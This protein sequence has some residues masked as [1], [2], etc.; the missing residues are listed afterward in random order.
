MSALEG[1]IKNSVISTGGFDHA[2][3]LLVASLQQSSST[4][5]GSADLVF[6]KVSYLLETIQKPAWSLRPRIYL[7]LH[8][9]GHVDLMDN[10]VDEGILDIH[11][12]FTEERLPAALDDSTSR[13]KFIETQSVVLTMATNDLASLEGGRHRNFGIIDII[14]LGVT[15]IMKQQQIRFTVSFT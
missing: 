10:F 15:L 14:F 4:L 8:I 3:G 6:D 2:M 12:P 1:R 9:I 7:V 11:F 13:H 5:S